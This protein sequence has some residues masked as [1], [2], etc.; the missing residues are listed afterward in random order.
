MLF[1]KPF[2]TSSAEMEML[3]RE[4]M[5]ALERMARATRDSSF[6]EHLPA[7]PM[8]PGDY[9]DRVVWEIDRM[10]AADLVMKMRDVEM[11]S[12]Q[13]TEMERAH[14]AK[15]FLSTAKQFESAAL[16]LKRI[17]VCIDDETPKYLQE[18]SD[19][20]LTRRQAQ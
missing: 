15:V 2:P 4:E 17:R 16:R 11:L 10:S 12:K 19:V 8:P 20:P 7:R 3:E 5:E 6:E 13:W 9:V 14:Y 1:D 18:G